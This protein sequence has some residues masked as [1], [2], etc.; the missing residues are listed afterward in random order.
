MKINTQEIKRANSGYPP[1]MAESDVRDDKS[2]R[3]IRNSHSLIK[4]E[5]RKQRF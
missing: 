2:K 4:P 5:V 3:R 1:E